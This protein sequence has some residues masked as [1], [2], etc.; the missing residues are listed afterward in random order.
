M[1]DIRS[2]PIPE[3]STAPTDDGICD[4]VLS[5]RSYYVRGL[6]YGIT[7]PLFSRSSRTDIHTACNA[8]LT[9]VQKQATENRQRT[10]QRADELAT[11]V[12]EYQ[13][14]QI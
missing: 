6:G 11:C 2:Q 10:E 7:A 8:R 12:D 9:E 14:L 5:T 4:P 13:L 3:G 1:I